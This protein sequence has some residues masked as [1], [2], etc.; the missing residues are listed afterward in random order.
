MFALFLAE[1]VV[2]VHFLFVLFIALGGLL[3]VRKRKLAWFHLPSVVYGA[4]IEFVGWICPLTPL[5]NWLRARAGAAT[6]HTGFIEHY[7]L[8]VLYPAGLTRRVQIVLGTA[9]LLVNIG[10]YAWVILRRRRFS[11]SQ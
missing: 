4:A 8:P 2:L 5:E 9:V 11:Q 1:L 6:Y 3:V 10:V 7:L